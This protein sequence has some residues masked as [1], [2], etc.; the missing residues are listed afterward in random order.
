MGGPNPE[1]AT[2][3]YKRGGGCP[4][5]RGGDA[6]R[7]N[8]SAVTPE[9]SMRLFIT[10][11]G[12]ALVLLAGCLAGAAQAQQVK[13][14][15]ALAPEPAFASGTS[16]LPTFGEASTMTNGVPNLLAS[17]AQPGELGI[18]TRLTVRK[19]ARA[20]DAPPDLRVMGA[21]AAR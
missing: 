17:N 4:I 9:I 11:A 2:A 3:S 20:P 18:Q 5:L 15:P 21:S 8:R 1:H 12:A 14:R 19:T 7:L 10:S 13:D 6:P 16:N